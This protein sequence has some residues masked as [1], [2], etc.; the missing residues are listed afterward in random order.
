MEREHPVIDTVRLAGRPVTEDDLRFVMAVWND[1]RVAPTVGGIRTEQQLRDRI[2]RWTR[3]W[4]DHGF[5]VTLFEER[6]SGQPVGWGGLQHS[7]IGI[8]ECLTVGYV[9]APD[10]WGHGYATEIASA[11]VAHA[12]G[13]L[14][15]G[16]LYA[17]VLSTNAASRRVLEKV[18]LSV[19]CEV[20]HGDHLEVIYEIAQ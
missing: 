12:F 17:S 7:T 4:N 9:I 2:E 10:A 13:V 8:G 5:G 14:G 15:I 11:S 16:T 6:A 1:S 19:H 20:N 3:H 18:G